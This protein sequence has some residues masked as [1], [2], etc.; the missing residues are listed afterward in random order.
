[1]QFRLG[2]WYRDWYI[3]DV[4]EYGASL[5]VGLPLG[6]RG[7]MVDVALQ[8]GMREASSAEWDE[9]FFGI[10]LTLTGVGSWGKT[11]NSR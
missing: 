5:G 2:A 7:T 9:T 10:R 11:N 4:S 8:G 1:M 6:A 3:K